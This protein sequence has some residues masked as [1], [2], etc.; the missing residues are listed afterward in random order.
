M[1][2]YFL[3]LR[4]DTDEILDPEGLELAD[5]EAV[6]KIV[7]ESARDLLSGELKTDGVVDLRLRIDAEDRFGKI[8][9]TLRFSNA[10]RIIPQLA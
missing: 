1:S 10:F 5:M 9:H 7:L 8:V 4:D 6:Q 2:R 3:H